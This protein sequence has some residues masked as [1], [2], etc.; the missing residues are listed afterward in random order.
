MYGVFHHLEEASKV[1]FLK[2]QSDGSEHH[3]LKLWMVVAHQ[4]KGHRA[5]IDVWMVVPELH[6]LTLCLKLS[7]LAGVPSAFLGFPEESLG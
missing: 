7:D 3:G 6:D 2:A 5:Q 1:A 4:P